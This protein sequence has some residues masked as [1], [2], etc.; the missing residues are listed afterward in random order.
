[1]TLDLPESS[2]VLVHESRFVI[3]PELRPEL[4][5][6]SRQRPWRGCLAI[7]TDWAAIVACFAA[8]VWLEHGAV[9][10]L[11]ALVIATRQ[12]ALAVLMHDAAHYRLCRNHA[13]NDRLSNWLLAYPVLT[14]TQGYRLHHLA[15]HCHLNTEEDPD[16]RRKQGPDWDFPKSRAAFLALCLRDLVGGGFIEMVRAQRHFRQASA[17]ASKS[18]QA[19]PLDRLTFYCF[20]AAIVALCGLW[21]EALLL[22]FVPL[23]TFMPVIMRI[24]SI[25]EHSALPGQHDLNMT[26]NILCPWW[27]RWLLVPH[28]VHYH[29]DHHLFPSVPFYNLPALHGLLEHVPEYAEQAHQ[30]DSYFGAGSDSVL[31]DL[32]ANTP[33]GIRE[34]DPASVLRS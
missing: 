5:Q 26:R 16:W 1:M 27:E 30:N 13:W 17:A 15:H 9:W 34:I 29:L 12:H 33:G 24:R 4:R 23:F 3:P 31:T 19:R 8:V 32:T 22:W 18:C 14:T 6:L 21:L 7:A 20:V 11:A 2:A 28:N 25:A 10:L